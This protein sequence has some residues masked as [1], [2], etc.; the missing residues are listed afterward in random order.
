[1]TALLNE[2]STDWKKWCD[3]VYQMED[4]HPEKHACLEQIYEYW[5]DQKAENPVELQTRQKELIR[6]A[7]LQKRE[8]LNCFCAEYI[9]LEMGS[10]TLV[11]FSA[12]S[13]ERLM[14]ILDAFKAQP[15]TICELNR[16]LE[17]QDDRLSSRMLSS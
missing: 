3:L 13:F 17:K 6:I 8:E 14:P 12:L 4:Q 5:L 10:S 7:L 11:D 9:G 1:M 15:S 16:R 2:V